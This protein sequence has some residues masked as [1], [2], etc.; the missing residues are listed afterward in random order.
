MENLL[1]RLN[2]RENLGSDKYLIAGDVDI[3]RKTI[4]VQLSDSFT[5]YRDKAGIENKFTLKCLRKS[6]LTKLHTKTGFVESMGY[7]RSAK[8]TLG[9]YID[10]AE[11]VK[12]VRRKGFV[13]FG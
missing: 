1:I 6:F 9:N 11:V 3:K 12:E 8:V 2:F 7:Q 4:A 13:Y 10:K 5:F